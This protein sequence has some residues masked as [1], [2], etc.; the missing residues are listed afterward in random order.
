[1]EISGCSWHPRGSVR[2]RDRKCDSFRKRYREMDI[3]LV[4][5]IQFLADKESTQKE[6]FHTFSTTVM[7]ADRKIRALMDERRSVYNQVGHRADQPHQERSAAQRGAAEVA[8]EHCVP[9]VDAGLHRAG[10]ER[11]HCD[12]PRP[13]LCGWLGRR[14]RP[15]HHR[16]SV[17]VLRRVLDREHLAS[18][19]KRKD[20]FVKSAPDFL[21]EKVEDFVRKTF[22]KLVSAQPRW[23]MGSDYVAKCRKELVEST[24]DIECAVNIGVKGGKGGK[25]VIFIGKK[26][27]PVLKDKAEEHPSFTRSVGARCRSGSALLSTRM[28]RRHR[29]VRHAQSELNGGRT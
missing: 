3:L 2:L 17:E 11:W 18:L 15:R 26:L 9:E 1:M 23:V 5:D 14:V 20:E 28:T 19:R 6:F 8:P 21:M 25:Y 27:L 4:D 16:P 10:R 12:R 29:D 22:T 24:V 7:H 13:G